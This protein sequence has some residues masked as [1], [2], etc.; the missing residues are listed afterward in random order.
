MLELLITELFVS[1]ESNKQETEKNRECAMTLI[2][3]KSNK[4]IKPLSGF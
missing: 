1:F 3:Y 4:V 2:R